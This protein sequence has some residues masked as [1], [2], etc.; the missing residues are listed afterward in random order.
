MKFDKIKSSGS[1][2]SLTLR[3]EAGEP[4]GIIISSF[5]SKS[6]GAFCA[7]PLNGYLKATATVFNLQANGERLIA[8]MSD[9]NCRRRSDADKAFRQWLNDSDVRAKLIEAAINESR[10]II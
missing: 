10:N 2:L 1:G 7:N 9:N 5:Y 4:V 8:E 3:N 6:R